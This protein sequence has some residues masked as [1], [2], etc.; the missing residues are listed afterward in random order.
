MRERERERECVCVFV[1]V[2][3]ASAQYRRRRR[4]IVRCPWLWGPARRA[5]RAAEARTHHDRS[6]RPVHD[7][8]LDQVFVGVRGILLILLHGFFSV[9]QNV[10]LRKFCVA[11]AG[12]SPETRGRSVG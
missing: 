1:A 6:G 5:V 11:T 2:A 3:P 9:V 10:Y 12:A 8:T 7:D 4:G